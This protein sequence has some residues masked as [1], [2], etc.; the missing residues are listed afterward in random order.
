MFAK[1]GSYLGEVKQHRLITDLAKKGIKKSLGFE[2]E[3]LRMLPPKVRLA[4]EE[5]L[6]MPKGYED[7]PRP[8]TL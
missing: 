4:P 8:E 5:P 6:D 2:P 3:R 7:F 1:S